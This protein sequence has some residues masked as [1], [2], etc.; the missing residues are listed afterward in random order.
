MATYRCKAYALSYGASTSVLIGA[1]Y[2]FGWKAIPA[3]LLA[4]G[5]SLITWGF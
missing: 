2:V 5:L 1:V 4:L 3:I